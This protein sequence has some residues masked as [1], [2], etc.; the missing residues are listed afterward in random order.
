MKFLA[1]IVAGLLILPSFAL[2]A[3]A[4]SVAQQSEPLVGWET[5]R[6]L[7]RLPQLVRGVRTRQFSSFD[8]TGGNR[9]DGFSGR[10]SCLRKTDDGCVIAEDTGAGEIRSLWF[11]RDGGNVTANGDLIVKLDGETVLEADLQR[12]V[13]GELGAPFVAPLVGNANQSSGGVYLKVPMPYRES[14]QVLTEN[15]TRFYILSYRSF[16]SP[17]GVETF[18]PSDEARDV[19][20]KMRSYGQGDPKPPSPDEQTRSRSFELGAWERTTLAELDGGAGQINALRLRLPQIIGPEMGRAISDDGRAFTGASQ[21]TVSVDPRNEGVRLTRRLATGV[22]NQRARIL[23]DGEAVAEWEPVNISGRRWHD[24]QVMLPASATAGKEEI[25]VRNEFISSS[26]DFN[27]FAYWTD[28]MVEGEAMRTDS[29]DIGPQSEGSERAHDYRI[30]DAEWEGA[31]RFAYPLSETHPERAA[32]LAASDDVLQNTHLQ[33]TFDGKKTVDAPLGEFF[34]SGLGERPVRSLFFAMDTTRTGYYSAWWPMPYRDSVTVE[35]ANQSDH[36]IEGDFELSWETG[37]RYR[38]GLGP[39][40][41]MG[42]FHASGRRGSVTRNDDW[43]FI[44]TRG[45]GKFVG[46][47]HTMRSRLLRD[48]NARSYLEGD[49][50]VYV[51]GA[52]SPALHGTGTEDFYQGGWYFSRGPFSLPTHGATAYEV[53]RN[54]C[55]IECDSTY[56]LMIGDAVS[57]DAGLRFSIEHGP[58]NDWPARYGSTAFWYGR[59]GPGLRQTDALDVGDAGSEQV[60]DYTAERPGEVEMLTS[61]FEGDFDTDTLRTDLRATRAP[62]S[63]TLDVGETGEGGVVLRRLSDQA[64]AYQAARVFI[65]GDE[66]GVWRQPLGNDTQRWLEDQFQVPPRYVS[67]G[68]ITVRLDPLG[69]APAWH[70]ARYEVLAPAN[71]LQR[72]SSR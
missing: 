59:E 19:V 24:Q 3:P 5:Y 34:G 2:L 17:D 71:S 45:R 65:D 64:E 1:R 23:V 29:V 46:V 27:E 41:D 54:G 12:V 32:A 48:G 53:G 43:V 28:S 20:E 21:F 58:H 26:V 40:G 4:S 31:R 52:R 10:F 22:A 49:E 13:N 35:L 55:E 72:M 68:E 15:E 36:D 67:G 8:R 44:D 57:F 9:H 70:A 56:R 61:V 11:T 33:I 16:D 63:F 47:S 7:D 38:D 37:G 42:Y 60:H 69:D 25:T 30:E 66:V 39:E 50:R 62:V 18:D 14:M 51:D 6:Q